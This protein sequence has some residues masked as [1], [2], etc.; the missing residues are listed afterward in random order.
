MMLTGKPLLAPL[1]RISKP[2]RRER[3]THRLSRARVV[4]VGFALFL[5]CFA[6]LYP[7]TGCLAAQLDAGGL[8]L[9]GSLCVLLPPAALVVFL[10]WFLGRGPRPPRRRERR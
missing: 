9:C 2:P 1:P 3:D 5:I 4:S 7:V 6:L 10:P 8:R